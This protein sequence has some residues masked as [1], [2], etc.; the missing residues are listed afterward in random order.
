MK[1]LRKARVTQKVGT[2]EK[3]RRRRR[4]TGG[5]LKAKTLEHTISERKVLEHIRKAPFLVSLHYAFQTD[6][7]L[8]LVMGLPYPKGRRERWGSS[9]QAS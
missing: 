4:R 5:M 9:W 3:G 2:D 6:T 7:K 1:V 8:H